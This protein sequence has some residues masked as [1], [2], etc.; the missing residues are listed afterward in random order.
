MPSVHVE[1]LIVASCACN[2]SLGVRKRQEGPQILMARQ[3]SQH[4]DLRVQGETLSQNVEG[5]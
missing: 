1:M 5:H 3:N 2:P 4:S